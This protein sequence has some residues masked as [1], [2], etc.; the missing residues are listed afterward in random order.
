MATNPQENDDTTDDKDFEAEFQ[1]LADARDGVTPRQEA[2]AERTDPP[3]GNA[4]VD[5]PAPTVAPADPTEDGTSGTSTEG[6]DKPPEAVASDDPWKDVPADIRER[7]VAIEK[8][9]D[10]ARHKAQ[11][12]ANRVA[13]LSRKI[14]ALSTSAPAA[15]V[16]KDEEPNEAQKALDDKVKQLREDYPEVADPLLEL[17]AAEREKLNAV[18]QKLETVEVDRQ[19]A[20]IQQQEAL[21]AEAH[22]DWRDTVATPDFQTWMEAQPLGIQKLAESYDA[23]ETS[24][25]ITLFKAESGVAAKAEAPVATPE[26]NATEA[27]RRE[28]LSGGVAIKSRPAP[29]VASGPPD[30]FEGAAA[31]YQAKKDREMAAQRGGR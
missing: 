21:L 12:D 30:D 24:T 14:Q 5:E 17:L 7:I 2:P 19:Q 26:Q 11:S 22:P 13:A 4:P 27:R 15:P 25:V 20:Y 16:K 31:Y 18:T 10:E 9:R 28:Q 23:R 6:G 29:A 8:E 1:R 3:E